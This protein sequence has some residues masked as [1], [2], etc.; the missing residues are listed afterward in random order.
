MTG[1]P[2][3]SARLAGIKNAQKITP[4]KLRH[5]FASM[6]YQKTKDIRIIQDL[7]GHANISTTQIYTHTDIQQKKEAIEELPEL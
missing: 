5:T 6:I 4:H 7:L 3:S 2:F 1:L